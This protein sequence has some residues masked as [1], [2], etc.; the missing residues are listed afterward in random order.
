MTTE[1]KDELR[2]S[3]ARHWACDKIDKQRC[4]YSPDYT[5]ELLNH[6]GLEDARCL[7]RMI[8]KEVESH[9]SAIKSK[10]TLLRNLRYSRKWL[11][12]SLQKN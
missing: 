6:K 10:Q 1:Q 4:N 9:N 3:V 2:F 7:V 11:S 5:L 12:S 8:V